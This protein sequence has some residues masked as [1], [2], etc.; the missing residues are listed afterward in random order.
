[1]KLINM[2][3]LFPKHELYVQVLSQ[4]TSDEFLNKSLLKN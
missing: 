2:T 1:M 3:V 4:K